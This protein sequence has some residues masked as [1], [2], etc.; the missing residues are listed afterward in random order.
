MKLST[1]GG[2]FK[3]KW[4]QLLIGFFTLIIVAISIFRIG[5]D[6]FAYLFNSSISSFQA[7]TILILSIL[8]FRQMGG[9]SQN[10]NLW[11][12]LAIGWALWTIA[13]F[14][15]GIA[16]FS[17]EGAPFP[18]GADFF[19]LVGYI[20]MY[21][22]L[23]MR[24]RSIPEETSSIQKFLM[25]LIGI[26][27]VGLTIIFIVVPQI[28]SY[29]PGSLYE[30]ILTIFYP[31]GDLVLFIFVLRVAFKYQQGVSGNAW[32]WVAFGYILN[33]VSD[34][35][36]AY[37]SAN[38]LYYPNGQVNFISLIAS[39]TL[40][41]VS[42]MLI[43]LGLA[44]MRSVRISKPIQSE[45]A[46][47]VLNIANTHILLFT[48]T[49]DL[50]N[51]TSKN[52]GL[53]FAQTNPIGRSLD[54]VLGLPVNK[55][56]EVVSRIKTN[57]V[58]E[59]ETVTVNT[60][61]GSKEVQISGQ[62][63]SS[64]DGE[65]IGEILLIRLFMEDFTMDQGLTDYEKSIIRSVITKSGS[66]EQ[67]E[68]KNLLLR[69]YSSYIKAYHNLAVSEG[70]EAM[71][72]SVIKRLKTQAAEAGRQIDLNHEGF[73]DNHNLPLEQIRP[74]LSTM[75][76]TARKIVKEITDEEAVKK[77]EED[78]WAKLDPA[79]QKRILYFKDEHS[80]SV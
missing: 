50:I 63:I 68:I 77:A 67:S 45:P 78:V 60:R 27:A 59:E 41:S 12:G 56:N 35:I 62:S 76:A 49:Y 4:R 17:S 15:W 14:W 29:E 57:R 54:G 71:A 61:L 31:I 39:D 55:A 3:S 64:P 6:D 73:I 44:I 9:K 26:M 36:F 22:V 51:D 8:L 28:Q 52:F 24:N 47:A 70:G 5:G 21:Y 20:P 66:R 1:T 80:F 23:E 40:Y 46:P 75:Q 34:L 53:V 18:S 2:F 32:L 72:D 13:E 25:W 16:S 38:G 48:D 74:I 65:Y 58:M 42:Y 11:L 43:I 79:M 7:L 69:Y 37:A 19:W 30:T 10:R 33:T